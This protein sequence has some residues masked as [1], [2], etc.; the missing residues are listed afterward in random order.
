MRYSSSCVPMA[1]RKFND[2]INISKIADY[3]S[4][5]LLVNYVLG[6]I[7]FMLVCFLVL[8]AIT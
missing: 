3:M 2:G 5:C 1:I 8:T 7:V 4:G 6:Y